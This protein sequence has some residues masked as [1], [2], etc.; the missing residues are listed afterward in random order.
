M[1]QFI[2]FGDSITQQCFTQEDKRGFFGPALTDY[3][4][5]RLDVTNR[6]LSGYNTTQALKVLPQIIPSPQ[7]ARVR[8]M[9]IFFGANDARLP[10]TPGGPQQHVSINQY[11]NNLRKIATHS[12]VEAHHSIRVVLITPPPVDERKLLEA[13]RAKYPDVV[14]ESGRTV[15]RRTAHTT[16]M[17]AQAVRDVG[18]DLQLPVL[19]IW[20]AMAREAGHAWKADDLNDFDKPSFG[21]YNASVNTTLQSFLH[22]GLHF[23]K[24]AY[25]LLFDELIALIEKTWPDD[26]PDKIPFALPVWDD[27][28]GWKRRGSL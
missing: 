22:D 2:L 19:D 18:A 23:S 17:Y 3:Y 14:S 16:A 6:G 5:R 1:D 4:V 8:F 12:C 11:K 28:E 20:S 26:T 21:S 7:K 27:E 10:D 9:T 24:S 25:R 15:M 13:D